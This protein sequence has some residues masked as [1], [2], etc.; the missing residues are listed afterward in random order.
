[1]TDVTAKL[2]G[3]RLAP[4]KVRAVVD[5]IKGKPAMEALILLEHLVRKPAPHVA[6]LLKSAIASAEH[7]FDMVDENLYI[8]KITV[9]EGMKLKRYMPKALGAVN[10]IQKKTSRITVILGEKQQGL[11][12]EHQKDK[13]KDHEHIAP[14]AV[15]EEKKPEV[16]KELGIKESFAGKLKS[17]MFQRKSI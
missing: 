15:H 2:N 9:D 11:K 10:P 5:L 12:R 6:K 8:K 17:R 4:R 1:M 7:N 14:D 3:I 13:D 16:K